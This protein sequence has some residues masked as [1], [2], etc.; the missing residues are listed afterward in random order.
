MT[1]GSGAD[2]GPACDSWGTTAGPPNPRPAPHGRG[3]RPRPAPHGRV[4]SPLTCIPWHSL[5]G[6]HAPHQGLGN[7][8]SLPLRASSDGRSDALSPETSLWMTPS[9]QGAPGGAQ[10]P[11][12]LTTSVALLRASPTLSSWSLTHPFIPLTPGHRGEGHCR[13]GHC[14]EGRDGEGPGECGLSCRGVT[15]PPAARSAHDEHITGGFRPAPPPSLE[16]AGRSLSVPNLCL[17]SGF[18]PWQTHA[19]WACRV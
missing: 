12:P 19:G 3:P 5:G 18:W 15:I 6:Q 1:V 7:K 10:W 2:T 11:M 16:L 9:L 17:D 13:E 14:G 8:P 4:P